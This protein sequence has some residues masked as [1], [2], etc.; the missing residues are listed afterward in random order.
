MAKLEMELAKQFENDRLFR[1]MAK[2]CFVNERQ[3]YQTD[4]TKHFLTL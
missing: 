2:F 3:S 1:I 4:H